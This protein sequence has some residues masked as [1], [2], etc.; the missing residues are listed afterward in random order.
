MADELAEGRRATPT[1][2][3]D[4]W[5]ALLGDDAQN[6]KEAKSLLEVL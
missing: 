4:R 3:F 1:P 5:F 6:K 2:S